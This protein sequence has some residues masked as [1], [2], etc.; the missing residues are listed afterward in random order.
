MWKTAVRIVNVSVSH[1]PWRLN[2][3]HPER[4]PERVSFRDCLIIVSGKLR[5][6]GGGGGEDTGKYSMRGGSAVTPAVRRKGGERGPEK[7]GVAS[8]RRQNLNCT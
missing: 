4:L 1:W 7:L 2:H 6:L 5:P 3:V 8:W